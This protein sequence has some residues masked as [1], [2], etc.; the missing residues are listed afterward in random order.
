MNISG[1][2]SYTGLYGSFN[3]VGEK[4]QLQNQNIQQVSPVTS[5]NDRHLEDFSTR[6][7]A[8]QSVRGA[9]EFA[10]KY[11]A[12]AEF[13]LIGADSDIGLLD[14]PGAVS[15]EQKA[16]ILNQYKHYMGS[17]KAV[18]VISSSQRTD[19]A[20]AMENFDI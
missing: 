2:R 9:E 10:E 16:Q 4:E 1:I 11:D 19:S 13:S 7:S 18:G 3:K 20:R 17:S 6:I 8:E 12:S 15:K 5:S 14:R